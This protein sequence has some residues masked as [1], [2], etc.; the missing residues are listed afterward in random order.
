M[1]LRE[2]P[3]PDISQIPDGRG[4]KVKVLRVGVDGTDKEIN[5]AEYGAAPPGDDYLVT[6]HESFGQVVEVGRRE[7]DRDLVVLPGIAEVGRRDDASPLLWHA[8]L[9]ERL[10]PLPCELVD[11]AARLGGV[12]VLPVAGV[13]AGEIVAQVRQQHAEIFV[14]RLL[15]R[16]NLELTMVGGD[17]FLAVSRLLEFHGEVA[18]R[19]LVVGVEFDLL[20]ERADGLGVII[21]ARVGLSQVIPAF[22]EIRILIDGSLQHINGAAIILALERFDSGF[23][24]LGRGAF[25]PAGAWDVPQTVN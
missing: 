25:D 12:D 8:L 3:E 22:F 21:H 6:G 11:D 19:A 14:R 5:A 17:R 15:E 1:H 24:K 16:N 10:E 4:V 9:G 18:I 2:I 13:A 20:A 7:A 23:V